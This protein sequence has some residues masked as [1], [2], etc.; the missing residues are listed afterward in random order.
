LVLLRAIHAQRIGLSGGDGKERIEPQPLVII[1]IF[2]TG[3]HAQEALGA[4]TAD[5]KV[6]FD[7]LGRVFP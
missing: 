5:A 2:V 4:N 1:E 3:G 7:F 6:G